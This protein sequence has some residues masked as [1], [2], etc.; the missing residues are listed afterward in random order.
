MKRLGRIE[1]VMESLEEIEQ[2]EINAPDFVGPVVTEKI[3]DFLESRQK[4]LTVR[5]VGGLKA[6]TGVKRV[7]AQ[8]SR[9]PRT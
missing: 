2:I 7:Q 9:L 8:R 6:F 3:I 1:L 5:P 4:I